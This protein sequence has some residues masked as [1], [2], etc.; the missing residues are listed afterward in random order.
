M[1]WSD[2]ERLY[3]LLPALHRLRDGSAGEPLRA[4]LSVIEGE[5][6]TLESDI[7][8]LY[9]NWFIETC[10]DWVI[11]YIGDLV[12]NRPLHDVGQPLRADVAKTLS[13]RRRK[14]T[15]P[16]LAEL[17]RDVTGWDAH[18]VE[19]FQLLAWTQNV[20]HMRQTAAGNPLPFVGVPPGRRNPAAV[21]RVGTAHVRD[22][23]LLDRCESPF[24]ELARTIDVRPA[25]S[26]RDRFNIRKV[27]MF[28]WRLQ[29]Y[30][31]ESVTP[32]PAAGAIEDG[33]PFGYHVSPLGAD[34][35]LFNRAQRQQTRPDRQGPEATAG[36]P[37][38]PLALHLDLERCRAVQTAGAGIPDSDYV[39]DERAVAVSMGS[40]VIPPE[41]IVV[42]DLKTWHR[43]PA[44]V[45]C[46]APD[47]S[48][49]LVPIRAGL[50][51]CRGR[52]VFAVGQEPEDSTTNPQALQ[53]TWHYGFSGDLGGGPY[54]RALD[55][56]VGD[57][58]PA[59]W[60]RTVAQLA[61]GDPD[62]SDLDMA[63]TEWAGLPTAD[64][65]KAVLTIL[66]NGT[67]RVSQDLMLAAGEQL[68]IQASTGHRPTIR[69]VH[70]GDSGADWVVEGVAEE[71]GDS[72][73]SEGGILVLNGLLIEGGLQARG[74]L[75]SLR[76]IHS[77][78]VPGRRLYESGV[79]MD[80][81]AASL[82]VDAGSI[83]LEIAVEHSILG[84]IRIA[85]DAKQLR[86]TD[87][88]VDALAHLDLNAP[89]AAI[90]ADR[91]G[92]QP[93][94]ETVLERAT[95]L[96]GMHVRQLSL[97]SE[98][99][100]TQP[101]RV[102]RRQTGCVRFS[103]V[104]LESITPRRHRCQPELAVQREGPAAQCRVTP[105]FTALRYGQ[106]GYAQLRRST[107]VEIRTGAEDGAE[108][109]AFGFLK[110]PQR[111]ANLQRR[112]DEYLPFGLEAALRFV[113]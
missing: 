63:L 35:P 65:K 70:G 97:A 76:V 59:S 105:D 29:S 66:D 5:L 57:G 88:V 84:P 23:D 42:L 91:L 71:P 2:G 92:S 11:P 113:T 107:A 31:L 103:Y 68:V 101:V 67:Y 17:A 75:R 104:P 99:I 95:V 19:F 3:Q 106:P 108:M 38:R 28:L 72:V 96:G 50:D 82:T 94:P 45:V 73:I 85:D 89:R 48:E 53:V 55:T 44:Q 109:G 16:L 51:P 87:S 111:E 61:T 80:V 77:T 15:V 8:G 100:V 93:G 27:G 41:Q 13:Y 18:V 33:T 34:V 10:D 30:E 36:G 81:E 49:Q 78:L 24:D 64:R 98:V 4:L 112:L 86:V 58:K 14:S 110:Q 40:Q 62:H 56:E 47:G 20:N 60:A 43:P 32:A 21:S 26:N 79:L 83:R 1:N 37:L 7:A 9:E 102:E 25:C 74:A 6:E 90:A 39:G 69:I 46:L 54:P 12:A 22:L 52:L